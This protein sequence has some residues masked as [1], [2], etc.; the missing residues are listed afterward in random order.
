MDQQ[1]KLELVRSKLSEAIGVELTTEQAQK[2]LIAL[3]NSN[4]IKKEALNFSINTK[5]KV[6]RYEGAFSPGK[7]P[8]STTVLKYK[9]DEL[10]AR[11]DT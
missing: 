3:A 9:D 2:V 8:Q 7:Q 6:E 5:V 1:E 11:E 4:A 10:I